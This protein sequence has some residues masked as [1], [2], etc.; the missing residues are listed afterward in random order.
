[1]TRTVR[2]GTGSPR[3][4]VASGPDALAVTAADLVIAAV[5]GAIGVRGEAHVALTG[6][7]SASGLYRALRDPSRMEAVDWS[8]VHLWFGDD[9]VV[10]LDHPDSNAGL[11]LR[12]LLTPADTSVAHAS[13]HPMLAGIDAS[14]ADAAA[15]AAARYAVELAAVPADDEGAPMFDLLLLGMGPDGHLLSVFP[16][17]PALAAEAPS[18]LPIPAPTHIGPALPRITLHPAVVAAA[19]SVLLIVGGAAKASV[20]ANVLEGDPA[21][22]RYPA[23]L[24]RIDTATWLLD[25]DSARELDGVRP[26]A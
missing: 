6:G 4:L 24:A 25:P 2:P 8:R 21:I 22:E 16:D 12:E 1:V 14:A 7:S 5:A 13:F 9:R 23:R 3:V 26:S 17:G 19:R 10:P 15:A 20:L 11:A 18:V